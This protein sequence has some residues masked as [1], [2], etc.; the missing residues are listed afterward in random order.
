MDANR[1]RRQ[2]NKQNACAKPARTTAKKTESG[3]KKTSKTRARKLPSGCS[4][5]P[6][7]L[8]IENATWN[9]QNDYCY[10]ILN[11]DKYD[12]LEVDLVLKKP[13]RRRLTRREAVQTYREHAKKTK[14]IVTDMK[15]TKREIMAQKC[16]PRI[17]CVT[18]FLFCMLHHVLTYLPDDT[19]VSLQAY[20]DSSRAGKLV[21]LYQKLGFKRHGNSWM[22]KKEAERKKSLYKASGTQ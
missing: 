18:R 5:V 11:Y 14:T 4:T 1:I 17:G 16:N 12:G 15:A 19:V 7:S 22:K 13:N 21:K 10:V 9:L 20:E 6:Y 2:K 8:L 3:A